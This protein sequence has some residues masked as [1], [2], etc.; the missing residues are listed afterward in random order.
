MKVGKLSY[1]DDTITWMG[2]K[3]ER[4]DGKINFEGKW[5]PEGTYTLP[6]EKH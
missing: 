2:E 4:K 3:F 5:H 6:W 1:D